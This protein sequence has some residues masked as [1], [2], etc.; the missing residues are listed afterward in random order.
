MIAAPADAD[1]LAVVQARHGDPF[2]VLGMHVE[3]GEVVVRAFLP[4]AQRVAVVNTQTGAPS[5]PLQRI[6]PAGFFAGKVGTG[7]PF[8][9]R[10][11]VLAGGLETDIED[12]Y[13]FGPLLGDVDAYLIAEGTHLRL[14]DVLGAH[15]RAVDY[16]PGVAFAV[17]APNASR[18]AVV[19]DFNHWDGR[20][21]AMRFR[22]E[23]G[24]WEL[25]VPGAGEGQ[26]YKY[27]I[28]AADGSLMPLKAD[29]FGFASEHPPATASIVA[30]REPYEGSGGAGTTALSDRHAPIA[31]YE[32][33]LGSWRRR[34]DEGNRYLSYRELAEELI[35][36]V[37]WMGF[38]HIELMPVAEFPFDGSWGYQQV[39]LYA[40]TSRFGSPHDFRAFIERAHDEGLGVIVD[41]VPGTF[42]D[43]RARFGLL[44]R[45]ASLRARRPAP[46]V[47]SRLEHVH[48]Q[49]RA[50]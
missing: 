38:T 13:R 31:I 17:W 3:D 29:P 21:H 25:F 2:S 48:L 45:H 4:R 40:P 36:Y 6:D 28:K 8:P 12:P 41:W 34:P 11:R 32:V 42:S 23:C 49:S 27:E 1:V 33:H 37:K 19:G 47:S 5:A 16:V 15:P 50:P 9:Y 10:L 43:R 30:R 22:Q 39:G 26:R 20:V 14:Y 24:V 44:R 35:P 7:A 46:R 18:V